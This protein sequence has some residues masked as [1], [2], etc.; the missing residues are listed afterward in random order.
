MGWAFGQFMMD[1]VFANTVI[2]PLM[3]G[4]ITGLEFG[5]G[6]FGA[7]FGSAIGAG[8]S[9]GEA[10]A[11]G[12][13]GFASGF[14]LGFAAGYSYTAGW[15]SVLHGADIASHNRAAELKAYMEQYNMLMLKGRI[16]EAA[17]LKLFVM[18][19]YDFYAW[20]TTDIFKSMPLYQHVDVIASKTT[21]EFAGVKFDW[22]GKEN[23]FNW[24]KVFSGNPVKG[25]FISVS[26]ESFMNTKYTLLIFKSGDAQVVDKAI[27][28][29]PTLNGR[30]SAYILYGGAH[31]CY[32]GAIEADALIRK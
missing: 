29:I 31:I 3:G 23:P 11:A 16:Q 27:R 7:G 6:G 28:V 10:F 19:N 13:L 1:I 24:G 15:Q 26:K 32:D 21:G 5:I 12:G 17:D 2:S 4:I 30:E 8:K 22:V 14:A 25:R 20:C 18:K 9:I